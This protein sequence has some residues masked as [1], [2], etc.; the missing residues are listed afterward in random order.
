MTYSFIIITH[1]FDRRAPTRHKNS[2]IVEQFEGKVHVD[3]EST[4]CARIRQDTNYTPANIINFLL[5]HSYK[6]QEIK[7]CVVDQDMVTTY[8]LKRDD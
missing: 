4:I 8:F 5:N 3:E 7:Q 2:K 1:T 6:L